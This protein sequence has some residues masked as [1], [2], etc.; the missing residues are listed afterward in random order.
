MQRFSHGGAVLWCRIAAISVTLAS[1]A[2]SGS[3]EAQLSLG[4]NA[5]G[6][7]ATAAHFHA[8]VSQGGQVRIIRGASMQVVAQSSGNLAATADDVRLRAGE[9]VTVDVHLESAAGNVTERVTWTPQEDW[10]YGVTAVVDT[11]RPQGFC[12]RLAHVTPLPT[13][14]GG[15]ADTL[16]VLQLGLPKGAT[17]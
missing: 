11:R 14:A 5:R 12:F 17:C 9:P 10:R 7:Y 15:I 2:C 16:F 13:A 6:E 3:P 1:A 8:D 4:F